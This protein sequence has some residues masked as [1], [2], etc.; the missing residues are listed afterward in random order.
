MKRYTQCMQTMVVTFLALISSVPPSL[1]DGGPPVPFYREFLAAP[2]VGTLVYLTIANFLVTVL[3]EY[4]VVYC[5]LGRPVKA[6]GKIFVWVL[7]A[8]FITNPAA[9][10]GM[11]FLA[12]PALLGSNTL[13]WAMIGTIEMMAVIVEF[14]FF[15]WVVGRLHRRSVIKEAVTALGTFAMALAANSVSFVIVGAGTVLI[16]LVIVNLLS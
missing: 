14:A 8:N 7:L 6:R 4:V 1:A 9:Q 3:V 13:S 16:G 2:A 15:R 5:F 11:V 12:D 10:L